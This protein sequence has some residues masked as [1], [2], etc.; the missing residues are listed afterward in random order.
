MV[1]LLVILTV[2]TLLAAACEPDKSLV[3][4]TPGSPVATHVE[5]E[6]FNDVVLTGASRSAGAG[7]SGTY[8]LRATVDGNAIDGA[9]TWYRKGSH[10]RADFAG[11]VGGAPEDVIVIAGPNYPTEPTLYV[12]SQVEQSCALRDPREG[13]PEVLPSWLAFQVLDV[14]AFATGL[15]FYDESART[16]I[17]QQAL[18]FVGRSETVPV[19]AIE[20][21]EACLTEDGLPLLVTAAGTGRTVSFTTTKL[22]GSVSEKDFDLPN[23]VQ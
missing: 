21:G 10:M 12:C 9:V 19:G 15:N 4:P 5:P 20:H 17:E 22:P 23:A 1:R 8:T 2:L 3:S 14:T 6:N 16:I 18:C 11:T 13:S 7:F